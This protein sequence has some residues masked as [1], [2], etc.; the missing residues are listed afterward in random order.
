MVGVVLQMPEAEEPGGGK[1]W[2]PDD[3]QI[4]LRLIPELKNK[5]AFFH[6]EWKVYE[7]GCWQGRDVAEMRRYIR[8][9]LRGLRE[10]GV[11]V[12]MNRIRSIASMLEDDLFIGDRAVIQSQRDH[13]KYIPLRNGLFNLETMC[14][15][16]HKPELM[17]TT[18][19]DFDYN[20]E[21]ECKVFRKYLERSLVYPGTNKHDPTLYRLLLQ[22][23]AYSMTART[24][25][26]AS[27]WLVGVP[28][29][30]KSTL[31]N[32]L[33]TLMGSLH[34]TIDLNQLGLNRFL[35]AGTVGKRV[36]SFTEGSSNAV[37]PDG[38]YKALI[39]GQDD[40]Q[41]DVKNR[42]PITFR[43]VAKLW[44]AMNDGQMPRITDRSGATARRLYII[45]FNR[46][47]A[48][49]ERDGNLEH[50]LFAERSGIFNEM[51][52]FYK[53]LVQNGG[54][55]LCQQSEEKKQEYITE[56]DTESSFIEEMAETHE[57]YSE[58]SSVLYAAYSQWCKDRGFYP[59][60]ALQIGGEW[61]RLGFKKKKNDVMYWHGVRLR[62]T[63]SHI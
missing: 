2:K 1:L 17:F 49:N 26:Q 57:L 34:A 41:V 21:A 14:M 23:M 27:F 9:E 40:L 43:P 38:L 15:E 18:Q 10:H 59:K 35:L 6:G 36:I 11:V 58:Q 56:N 37:L 50:K 22:A 25:L 24:D 20:P 29:S 32:L 54:F 19:L 60:N 39:G 8:K 63:F 30:G 44:W 5:V 7:N 42:D 61:R 28:A 53:R 4:A 55:E 51:I 45:P 62:E 3:D 48:E 31:V 33:K 12:S 16:D 52:I 47:F 46:S 13:W